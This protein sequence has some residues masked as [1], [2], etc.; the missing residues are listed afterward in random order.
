LLRGVRLDSARRDCGSETPLRRVSVDEGGVT[1]ETG[2]QPGD[3]G[4]LDGV[5]LAN[6]CHC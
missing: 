2:V 6:L 1:I 5:V 4:V 3:D